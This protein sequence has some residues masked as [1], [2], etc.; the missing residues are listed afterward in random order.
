M[1]ATYNSLNQIDLRNAQPFTYDA[2]GNLTDDGIR[3]YA[4]DAEQRLIRIGY[5]ATPAVSTTLRYDGL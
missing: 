4:W 1:T 5:R 2:A 3:T